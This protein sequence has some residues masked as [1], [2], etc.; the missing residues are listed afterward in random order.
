MVC[1]VFRLGFLEAR[2]E[3]AQ[4]SSSFTCKLT[5][6]T[7]ICGNLQVSNDFAQSVPLPFSLSSVFAAEEADG[8]LSAIR[9]KA[10]MGG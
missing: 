10:A 9:G 8:L 3:K 6:K 4:E 1:L 7:S 5:Q 2:R